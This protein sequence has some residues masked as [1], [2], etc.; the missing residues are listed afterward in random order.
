MKAA[1]SQTEKEGGVKLQ[2]GGRS[3]EHVNV[4][5]LSFYL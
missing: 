2:A 1:D 3:Q 5:L 4:S